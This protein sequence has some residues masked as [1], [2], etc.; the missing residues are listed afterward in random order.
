MIYQ[1]AAIKKIKIRTIIDLLFTI[2]QDDF[3]LLNDVLLIPEFTKLP[4]DP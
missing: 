3:K 1:K 4:F 2:I